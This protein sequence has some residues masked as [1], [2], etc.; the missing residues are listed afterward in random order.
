MAKK[1]RKKKGL[2]LFG[3]TA[4]ALMLAAGGLLVV[5][6][7]SQ[8]INPVRT[9]W[10]IFFGILFIPLFLLNVFLLLWAFKR[11]SKAFA[12]PLLALLPSIFT[13]GEYYQIPSRQ[14][15]PEADGVTIVTYNVGRFGQY[16]ARNVESRTACQDSVF[17]F[18]KRS[19]ADIIC[20][21]E[22]Y[23]SDADAIKSYVRKY[24]P[25]YDTEYYVNVSKS[26]SYGNVT[27]SRFPV[28][29]KG[30]FDFENSANLVL[31]TDLRIGAEKI[32]VYNCHFES[33]NISPSRFASSISGSETERQ[34]TE[35][36]M[37]ASIQRRSQQVDLVIKDIAACP[38]ETIVAG[39]FN[40]T[41]LS[42]SYHRLKRGHLDTFQQ[43]GH[44]FGG[45]YAHFRHLLRID[46]VLSPKRYQVISHDVPRV[47]FSDHFPIITEID[48]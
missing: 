21:Q 26:G 47:K 6:Y 4:R 12:I 28:V 16:S 20:I 45:T 46:Y 43:A 37:R 7:L 39:D 27:I 24:F 33:Y 48:I 15:A 2:K 18:L 32:R 22:F 11:R 5:C 30:K 25:G 35:E 13:I 44:G 9:W 42:F 1:S 40:D 38:E 36:K 34:Q 19:G 10:L 31:Y 14:E 8:F 23:A 3:L 17:S 29:D 41:P